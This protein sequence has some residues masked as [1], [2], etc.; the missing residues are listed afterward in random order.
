MN[1]NLHL[2]IHYMYLFCFT[3]KFPNRGLWS[4]CWLFLKSWLVTGYWFIPRWVGEMKCSHWQGSNIDGKFY[5]CKWTYKFLHL[6]TKFGPKHR[7][8]V[9]LRTYFESEWANHSPFPGLYTYWSL[10]PFQMPP[11]L[12]CHVNFYKVG[13]CL[14]L[15]SINTAFS[16]GKKACAVFGS[17]SYFYV[18]RNPLLQFPSNTVTLLINCQLLPCWT[19]PTRHLWLQQM[20][21][22]FRE[23]TKFLYSPH[24]LQ[25]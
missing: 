16:L 17:W 15:T 24:F 4:T 21:L 8:F 9:Y 10:N 18:P 13:Q 7:E 20:F 1:L 3:Q 23:I 25:L 22:H 19:Q 2:W 14:W 6:T 12:L 11:D 5:S